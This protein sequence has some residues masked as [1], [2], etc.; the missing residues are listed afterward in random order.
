[1]NYNILINFTH[2]KYQEKT[3]KTLKTYHHKLKIIK[4]TLVDNFLYK[5]IPWTPYL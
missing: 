3:T 2:Q 4:F 5:Q 1:M